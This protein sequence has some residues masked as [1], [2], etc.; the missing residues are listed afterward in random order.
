MSSIVEHKVLFRKLVIAMFIISMLG[1][2]AFDLLNVPAQFSCGYPNVRLNG[3]FC[4]A[5]TS[6]FGGLIWTVGGFFSILNDLIN[7][8]IVARI[9]EA[10]ALVS[11]WLVVLPFFSTL[12][13]I[14]KTNSQRLQIINLT[15]WGIGCFLALK[16]FT[17]QTSRE[18]FVHL[19]YLLWGVWLYILVTVAA[20]ILEILV[21]GS[22]TK[23]STN[24]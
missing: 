4:G 20:I 3:D 14:R 18:Q 21:F 17:L 11:M 23:P 16:S 10:I 6:G 8:S 24:I 12:L 1:P 22:N 9:P 7:G 15:A 13:L 5:P 2:W 19:S